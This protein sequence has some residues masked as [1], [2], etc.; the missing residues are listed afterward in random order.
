MIKKNAID[1]LKS[2]LVLGETDETHD[3][4][5]P[6]SCEAISQVTWTHSM[7]ISCW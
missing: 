4:T 3:E 5:A 7:F 1:L 6:R 2:L